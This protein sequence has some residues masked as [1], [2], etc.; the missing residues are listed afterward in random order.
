MPLIIFWGSRANNLSRIL[1]N[2]NGTAPA[3]YSADEVAMLLRLICWFVMVKAVRVGLLD[4]FPHFQN[5]DGILQKRRR[6][7]SLWEAQSALTMNTVLGKP[8]LSGVGLLDRENHKT[9]NPNTCL[10]HSPRKLTSHGGPARI[11]LSAKP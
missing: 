6:T 7:E 9:R 1:N 5:E 4:G 11:S 2:A 10:Q 3:N 8:R